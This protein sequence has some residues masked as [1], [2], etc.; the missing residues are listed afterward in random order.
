MAQR[1]RC[2]NELAEVWDEWAA[3]ADDIG[4]FGYGP[5][6][7]LV[8]VLTGSAAPTTST[9]PTI[10]TGPPATPAKVT[11]PATA[12]APTTPAAAPA[13]VTKLT[14]K[15][16]F[17]KIAGER[18]AAKAAAKAAVPA[19]PAAPA[20]T[21]VGSVKSTSSGLLTIAEFKEEYTKKHGNLQGWNLSYIKYVGDNEKKA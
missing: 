4:I 10:S 16:I 20:A 8:Q 15:Q 11:A 19:A 3:S 7:T 17:R 6:P 9:L 5:A 21:G 14:P 12:A 2:R 1:R 13:K 18:V